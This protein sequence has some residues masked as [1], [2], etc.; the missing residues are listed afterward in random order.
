MKRLVQ[1]THIR[2]SCGKHLKKVKLSK[3]VELLIWL[4]CILFLQRL[5]KAADL[6]AKQ[7]RSKIILPDDI[8]TAKPTVLK[9]SRC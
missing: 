6:K 8:N 4:D 1:R 3:N 5:A 2:K 7:R 9:H